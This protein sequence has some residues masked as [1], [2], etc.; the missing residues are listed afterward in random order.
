MPQIIGLRAAFFQ[1]LLTFI[2]LPYQAMLMV[3]A[4]SV[5][6]VRVFITKQ[7]LLQWVTSADVEKTQKNSLGSY[8]LKM[9]VSFVAALAIFSFT[10]IIK[11]EAEAVGLVFL[12]MWGCS[13]F[14]AFFISKDRKEEMPYVSAKERADLGKTARKTWRYFEEFVG[15][16]TNYL[17]P[18][19]YQEDPPRGIAHRTSPT[20]IGLG[21]LAA[22]SARDLGYIGTCELVDLMIK[23]YSLWKSS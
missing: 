12:L 2:F 7:N 4:I 3:N 8:V 23:P 13:P 22:L 5:T 20:N 6:L 11:P 18:D 14:V 17:A 1:G 9:S 15:A 10:I 19:N 21:L 16:K